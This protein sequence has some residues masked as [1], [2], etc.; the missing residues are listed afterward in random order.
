MISWEFF[1]KWR[2]HPSNKINDGYFERCRNPHKGVHRNIFLAALNITDVVV[3]EVGF[4]GELDLAPAK[5][6]AMCANVFAQNLA[7]FWSF[8]HGKRKADTAYADYRIYTVFSAC[9]FLM[10]A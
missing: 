7:V 4:F 5:L 9:I 3:V 2:L 8:C 1:E 10:P 6:P